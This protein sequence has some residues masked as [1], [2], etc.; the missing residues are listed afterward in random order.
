MKFLLSSLILVSSLSNTVLAEDK[1]SLLHTIASKFAGTECPG[2]NC[3]DIVFEEAPTNNI[4]KY[5]LPGTRANMDRE[6]NIPESTWAKLNNY[7]GLWYLGYNNGKG[8]VVVSFANGRY[9]PKVCNDVVL[10]F[11]FCLFFFFFF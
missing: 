10:L 6:N 3:K 7:T 11:F 2:F 4:E 8:G 9:N 5:V 1:P